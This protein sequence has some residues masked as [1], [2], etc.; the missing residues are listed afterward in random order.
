MVAGA[1][2]HGVMDISPDGKTLALLM[3]NYCDQTIGDFISEIWLVDLNGQNK[4]HLLVDQS[5]I[6]S[7]MPSFQ[8]N[9]RLIPFGIAWAVDNTG[10]LIAGSDPRLGSNPP[11]SNAYYVDIASGNVTP[12]MDFSKG[13]PQEFDGLRGKSYDAP[14]GFSISPDGK[15]LIM[16]SKT[17]YL[18]VLSLDLPPHG[19]VPTRIYTSQNVPKDLARMSQMLFS[20]S[21]AGG[22]FLM[23]GWVITIHS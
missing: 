12:I 1:S 18:N 6:Q 4:P 2:L 3:R 20:S 13:T 15:K 9:F 19:N 11:A 10:L 23:Q 22:K 14:Y 8:R 7:G 16:I 17:P 21:G 5:Q